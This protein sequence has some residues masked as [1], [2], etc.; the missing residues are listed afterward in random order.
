MKLNIMEYLSTMAENGSKEVVQEHLRNF[1][2]DNLEEL[3]VNYVKQAYY[4]V[5][6]PS[7]YDKLTSLAM[8]PLAMTDFKDIKATFI[9]TSE[10]S[11]HPLLRTACKIYAYING[12]A[13]EKPMVDIF[14]KDREKN[15]SRYGSRRATLPEDVI[16]CWKLLS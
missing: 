14:V 9:Q 12:L 3:Y 8:V 11:S 13:F 2:L 6:H 15:V 5:R 1:S 4:S 7:E 16:C 10:F